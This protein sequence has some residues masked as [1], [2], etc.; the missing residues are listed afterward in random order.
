[1]QSRNKYIDFLRF[2]G[3]AMIVLAHVKAPFTIHQIRCFDVPLM[4][5]VSGLAYG[6]KTVRASWK[7][8]FLPRLKRLL[9]PI[10]IFVFLDL[11]ALTLLDKALTFDSIIKSILLCTNGAVGYVWIIKVFVLVMFATPIL[12]KINNRL[13]N[14][15]FLVFIVVLFF[16]QEGLISIT[17][18]ITNPIVNDI[19]TETIP[20]LLGY[21]IPFIFG[22]RLR[23][24]DKKSE[25]LFLSLISLTS[26]IFVII[27]VTRYGTLIAITPTFKYPPHS[28]FLIY[29]LLASAILWKSIIF[30]S[31]LTKIKL[32]TFIGENTIWIYI[33]HIIFVSF[34]NIYIK[35]WIIKY[36]LVLS[37]AVLIYHVQYSI[38]NRLL[39]KTQRS[40]LKYFI[41]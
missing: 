16:I 1:M 11:I 9:I 23:Q 22:L 26:I 5:F 8:Y 3:L 6:N 13:S 17:Q 40:Y 31:N 30:L 14:L 18:Y 25:H 27:Y 28:Y 38:V 7:E 21:S 12:I 4:L 36:I 15:S 2:V 33:W 37:L 20:Y 19:Y 32:F 35:N 29:G 24:C 34:A 41:G 10:Y 39:N